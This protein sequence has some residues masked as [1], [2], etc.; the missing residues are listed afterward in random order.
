MYEREIYKIDVKRLD[1]IS[2]AYPIGFKFS[3]L[4]ARKMKRGPKM[5]KGGG[6]GENRIRLQKSHGILKIKLASEWSA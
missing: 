2:S 6:G 3:V 1:F 4:A 5:T